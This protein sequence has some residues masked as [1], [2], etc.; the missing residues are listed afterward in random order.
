MKPSKEILFVQCK[1]GHK[2][3]AFSILDSLKLVD[4]IDPSNREF[5]A[6]KIMPLMPR[7]GCKEC[8][9]VGNAKTVL[10]PPIFKKSKQEPQPWAPKNSKGP[11][12]VSS[13]R[14]LDRVFHKPSCGKAQMIRRED[15]VFYENA[16]DAIKRG[17]VPCQYCRPG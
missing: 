14:T 9:S 5:M 12:V 10:L 1:C 11:R 16:E 4:N 6:R 3:T 2:V 8:G 15:E 17:Y 7:L 13:D